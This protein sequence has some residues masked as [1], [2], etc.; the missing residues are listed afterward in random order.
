[1]TATYPTGQITGTV[2]N[3]EYS[4]LGVPCLTDDDSTPPPARSLRHRPPTFTC[5]P[6]CR[7]Q[8][9]SSTHFVS[10]PHH[11]YVNERPALP[12]IRHVQEKAPRSTARQA[13]G[14]AI[15]L[16]SSLGHWCMRRVKGSPRPVHFTSVPRHG[17]HMAWFS[18]SRL[19][20]MHQITRFNLTCVE[21]LRDVTAK[22]MRHHV[23][24]GYKIITHLSNVS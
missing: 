17:I 15:G 2:G 7:S 19:H 6:H 3:R 5:Q 24:V 16:R 10:M 9:L 13:S 21:H 4:A 20:T 14:C 22:G 8:P 12:L 18:I 1:M 11:K 23:P